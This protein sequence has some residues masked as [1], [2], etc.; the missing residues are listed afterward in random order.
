MLYEF[1]DGTRVEAKSARD[2]VNHMRRS[3]FSR[4][5]TKSN[6]TFMVE[7]AKRAKLQDHRA[8]N[9][10]TTDFNRFV[11]ALLKYDFIREIKR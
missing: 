5:G 3:S 11:A 1:Q 6:R 10:P 7:L 8:T 4:P 9:I 2:L